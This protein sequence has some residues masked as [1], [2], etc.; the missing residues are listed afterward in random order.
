MHSFKIDGVK[1]ITNCWFAPKGYFMTFLGT[2]ITRRDYSIIKHYFET[3]YGKETLNHEKI[4]IDQEKRVP[5]WYG[6]FY[7]LYVWYYLIALFRYFDHNLAYY[8]I[9]FEIEAYENQSN[10]NYLDNPTNWKKYKKSLKERKIWW[11]EYKKKH[12]L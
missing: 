3:Y 5:L 4:H 7:L 6:T 2:I 9:P 12:N 1:I 11:T 10:M 8:S